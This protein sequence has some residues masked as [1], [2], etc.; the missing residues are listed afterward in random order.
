M[1]L[2]IGTALVALY[3]GVG[4][5]WTIVNLG[6]L[7]HYGDTNAFLW[8]AKA[9][10]VDEY[11]GFAYPALLAAADRW[12]MGSEMPRHLRW[13]DREANPDRPCVAPAGLISIQVFQVLVGALCLAY[14]LHVAF[15]ERRSRLLRGGLVLL[16]ALLLFDPLLNHF[17]LALMTDGLA[18][19]FSLAFCAALVDLARRRT[20]PWLAGAVLVVSYVATAGL[21]IE[22]KWVLLGTLLAVVA[23]WTV[24]GRQQGEGGER[25]RFPRAAVLALGG[26]G[27]AVTSAISAATF[28]PSVRWSTAEMLVHHRVIFPHL[29]YIYDELPEQTKA[30]VRPGAAKSY[31]RSLRRYQRVIRQATKAK[32]ELEDRLRRDLARAVL[33]LRWQV[34]VGGVARDLV[35]NT[36]ATASYYV[37]L[38]TWNLVGEESFR[39][40][41]GPD[42]TTWIHERLTMHH[43]RTSRA[44]L[45][46][47]SGVLAFAAALSVPRIRHFVRRRAWRGDTG[48]VVRWAPAVAFCLL[49]AA[50]FAVVQDLVQIRY[51]LFSHAVFLSLVYSG[52][53]Q[54][55]GGGRGGPLESPRPGG[56]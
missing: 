33:R 45:W 31:G 51:T 17:N 47:S 26:L 16:W 23:I 13:E 6:E 53:V 56:E 8:R 28:K 27:F 2:G 3:L 14:F 41:F 37:R 22:K 11:R 50:V 32:P 49:N 9:L 18:C 48:A 44:Y 30:L 38:V 46:L 43:P 19:S 1:L 10:V 29:R 24:L 35:E 54:A 42:G 5:T 55:G 34:I 15:G 21:R 12:C 7:P 36:F 4:L 39:K 52:L 40:V 20:S 25:L